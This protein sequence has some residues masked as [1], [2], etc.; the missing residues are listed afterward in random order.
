[1]SALKTILNIT[2]EKKSYKILVISG[3]QKDF[4]L[5]FI[6]PYKWLFR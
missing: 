3:K 2:K 1:M 5:I 4:Q 6:R